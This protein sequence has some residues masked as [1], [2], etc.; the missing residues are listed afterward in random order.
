MKKIFVDIYLAFNFGDDLFLDIL[1][2][3]FKEDKFTVNYVGNEYDEFLEQYSNVEKRK[4][5]IKDKILRRM[6]IK[7]NLKD[8][9]KIAKEHDSLVFIGGS[10]FREESYHKKLYNDR[11]ELVKEFKK[12]KKTI[13]IIGANFG[14][15]Q[16]EEF[17]EDY[18]NLF[19]M[20]TDVCFRDK[21]SYD[22]FKDLKNTRYESDIVFQ[23]ELDS[24]NK[25]EKKDIVG[26]SI[27]DL[28]HKVGLAKYEN[29]YIDSTIK[30]IKYLISK[31]NKCY[32]ISFCKREGDLDVIHQIVNRLSLQERENILIHEYEGD[33]EDT[34]KLI[35]SFKCFIAARF[36]ANIIG[37]LLNVGILPVIYSDKTI[38][39]LK[40]INLDKLLINMKEIENLYDEVILYKAENNKTSLEKEK[41]SSKRQFIKLKEYCS[42]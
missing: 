16:T 40:D 17:V 8:Y 25:S 35:S 24:Y 3:Q 15:F 14:P 32:L 26:F 18:R 30:A 39:M 12:N 33:L 2:K 11:L 13:Y 36:H 29:R 23:I 7:D 41:I 20:C 21:Y 9:K 37:L 34:I 6:K 4:Y 28:K 19:S 31:G 42:I 5:D 1:A 10:I 27:I 38:N 22:L